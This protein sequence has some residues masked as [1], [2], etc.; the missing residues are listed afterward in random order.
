MQETWAPPLGWEDPREEEVTT[1]SSTLAWEI[2]GQRSL[3]GY[4]P[5]GRTGSKRL[6]THRSGGVENA[7]TGIQVG[8]VS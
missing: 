1:R 5:W 6:S 4:S 7:G 3:V 2:H 8:G